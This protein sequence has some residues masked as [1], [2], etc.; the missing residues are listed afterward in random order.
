MIEKIRDEFKRVVPMMQEMRIAVGRSTSVVYTSTDQ[1]LLEGSS[2]AADEAEQFI[3][4]I[5][6]ELNAMTKRMLETREHLSMRR[7]VISDRQRERCLNQG[8][9]Q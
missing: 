2:E 5:A 3:V 8:N 7:R 9:T 4:A 1:Q 6:G